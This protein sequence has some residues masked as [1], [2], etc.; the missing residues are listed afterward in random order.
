MGFTSEGTSAV[1][2]RVVFRAFSIAILFVCLFWIAGMT[3]THSNHTGINV[4]RFRKY[5]SA[6]S[7]E[8]TFSNRINI[9]QIDFKFQICPS[10]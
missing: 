1:T 10:T 3:V 7:I 9:F 8:F 2:R 4:I 5:S 6:D